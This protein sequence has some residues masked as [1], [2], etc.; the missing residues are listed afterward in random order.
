M[1]AELNDPTSLGSGYEGV[2]IMSEKFQ[3]KPKHDILE[4][5]TSRLIGAV[6]LIVLG[7]LFLLSENKLLVLTGNWWALFIAVPALLM[8]YNAYSAYIRDGHVTANVR[9]S[10]SSGVI[11]T[12]V[13][14]MAATDRWGS[15]WPLFLIALGVLVL[16]GFTRQGD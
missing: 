16:F 4:N 13:T 10:L 14:I 8:L 12:L 6:A 15:L 2:A 7:I 1:K 5:P 9:K 3:E 11:L